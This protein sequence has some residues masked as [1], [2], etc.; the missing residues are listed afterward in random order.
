M[1]KIL[2]TYNA[3]DFSRGRG[4]RR[5]RREKEGLRDKQVDFLHVLAKAK[6][7]LSRDTLCQRA[8]AHP[9][10]VTLNALGSNNPEVRAAREKQIGYPSLIT[11]GYVEVEEITIEDKKET[12]YRIT[13]EGR[14]AYE[15]HFM[16]E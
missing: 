10:N 7:P 2:R 1:A 11:L 4:G 16:E 8:K 3:N 5:A 6:G 9:T 13:D 14:E 15:R 12:V